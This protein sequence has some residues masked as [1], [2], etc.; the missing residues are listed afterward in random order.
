M[1]FHIIF[2]ISNDR[3]QSKCL[4]HRML[5]SWN[6][7]SDALATQPKLTQTP[8]MLRKVLYLLISLHSSAKTNTAIFTNNKLRSYKL[9]DYYTWK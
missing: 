8:I 9:V 1:I 2:L 6:Q 3:S 7:N 4:E 5:L